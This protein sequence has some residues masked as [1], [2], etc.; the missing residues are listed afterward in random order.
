[1]REMNGRIRFVYLPCGHAVSEPALKELGSTACPECGKEFESEDAVLINP[2]EEEL[3][4]LKERMVRRKAV[5]AEEE[6]KRK[7]EK[8]AAKADKKASK[9]KDATDSGLGTSAEEHSASDEDRLKEKKRKR[10]VDDNGPSLSHGYQPPR[11][12][13][14]IN[15]KLPDLKSIQERVEQG[16]KG[17]AI[18]GIY[19]KK[20]DNGLAMFFQG[21]FG[22]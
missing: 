20:A 7:A 5:R 22:R 8:K 21:T 19:E 12:V 2:K 1:M 3:E 11:P 13:A 15:M 6:A 16:K 10:E 4:K 18:K 9:A 17:N 14:G